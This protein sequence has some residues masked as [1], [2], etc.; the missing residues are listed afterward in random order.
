M[1]QSKLLCIAFA[2][3][4]LATAGGCSMM[5]GGIDPVTSRNIAQKSGPY[6]IGVDDELFISVWKNETLTRNVP[7]RPDGMISLP[8]VHDV[9]AAG[10][11]PV[12]LRDV[13]KKRLTQYMNDPQ[14]SVTVQKVAS[15]KV[16]V[17]GE[18]KKPGS[19]EITGQSTVLDAL[20]KAEGLT[21]WASGSRISVLRK[22]GETTRKIPFNYA[23]ATSPSA[24][25][26]NF[27][28]RP[29]DIVVVP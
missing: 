14:V 10:L 23:R 24:A 13:L 4:C 20:A 27:Y 5:D 29:G 1:A 7:V 18:V 22:D 8:L 6:R 11:T 21:E 3:F 26:D 12:E 19:Y 25:T 28:L 9:K 15:F 16:S 17:M 2:L